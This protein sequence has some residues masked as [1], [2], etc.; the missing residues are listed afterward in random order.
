MFLHVSV[1][2]SVLG[3]RRGRCDI[4]A[5][6]AGLQAYTQR[7]GVEGSGQGGRLRGL[8]GGWSLQAHTQGG[9]RPTPRGCI[10]ACTEAHPPP[11]QTATAA[12]GT[13][14]TVMYSFPT[15]CCSNFSHLKHVLLGLFRKNDD[16]EATE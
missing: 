5:C 8:A 1:S 11:Q 4:P 16:K 10:P 2:H 12:G 6:L 3:G 15:F 9:C 7:G 13:H 14:P